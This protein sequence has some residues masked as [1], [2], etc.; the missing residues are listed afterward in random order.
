MI[1]PAFEPGYPPLAEA[2]SIRGRVIVL[3]TI[4]ANGIPRDP[5]VIAVSAANA[6]GQA[7]K[8]AGTSGFEQAAL[9]AVRKWLFAPGFKDG[10]PTAAKS[11]VE[12][13][14]PA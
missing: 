13:N 14:L 6:D 11:I 3:V 9:R 12:V 10:V 2:S 5:K 7:I 8:A 4:D 1:V